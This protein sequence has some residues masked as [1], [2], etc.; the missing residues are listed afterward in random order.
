MA[1]VPAQMHALSVETGGLRAE[2][3]ALRGGDGAGRGPAGPR[4]GRPGSAALVGE[5][6]G[7]PVVHIDETRWRANGRRGGVWT[8]ST[9]T[10][11]LCPGARRRAGAVAAVV[12]GETGTTRMVLH[13]VAAT[14]DGRG[15]HPGRRVPRPAA[16][17]TPGPRNCPSLDSY[18][19]L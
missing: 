18:F 4:A 16:R 15:R 5:A 14:G 10:V 12:L 9:P 6:R 7:R 3:A 19:A 13:A 17:P 1:P 11:R 2:G 8:L